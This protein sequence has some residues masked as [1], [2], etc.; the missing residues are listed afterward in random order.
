VVK[1][2]FELHTHRCRGVVHVCS[3]ETWSRYDL[4]SALAKIIGCDRGLVKNI[5]INDLPGCAKPKNLSMCCNKLLNETEMS[6]TS[7]AKCLKDIG[8]G[9]N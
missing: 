3:P 7:I 4:I 2:V 8:R 5:L 6:F 1:A 9:V